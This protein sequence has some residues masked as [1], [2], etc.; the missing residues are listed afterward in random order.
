[1]FPL[2]PLLVLSLFKFSSHAICNIQFTSPKICGM[3]MHTRIR[4]HCKERGHLHISNPINE[5]Q[6]A[7]LE[8]ILLCTFLSSFLSSEWESGGSFQSIYLAICLFIYPVHLSRYKSI[9]AHTQSLPHRN[10]Y[11]VIYLYIYPPSIYPIY[12][13]YLPFIPSAHI[14]LFPS[15]SD[16]HPSLSPQLALDVICTKSNLSQARRL[17]VL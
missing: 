5:P 9:Y 17:D 7:F 10:I 14:H 11:R 4:S 2:L 12:P 8:W 13:I 16:W 15:S 1:M 3:L 6:K